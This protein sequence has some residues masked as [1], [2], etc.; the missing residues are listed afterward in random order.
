VD[1][2]RAPS[3]S[4]TSQGLAPGCTRTFGRGKA[5]KKQ[6]EAFDLQLKADRKLGQKPQARSELY[7][8]TLAQAYIRDRKVNGAST[9]YLTDLKNLLNNHVLP[10]LCKKPVDELIYEDMLEI[11]NLYK[12]RS[13]STRNRY[14]VY[15]RA[16]FRFG[17]RH[18][19]NKNNPL[20]QWQKKK[21]PPR[22]SLLTLENLK[23][24]IVHAAP[25]LKWAIEVEWRLGTRPGPSEL[26][27]IKWDHIDFDRGVV[28][29]F[30]GKT[31]EWREIPFSQDFRVRL[32]SMKAQAKTEYVIEYKGRPMK[33]F[34]RSFQTACSKAGVSYSCRMYDVRH[35]FATVML[36]GGADLAAVSK[37]LGHSSTKMTADVYYELMKGEKAKAV[38]LLPS[39]TESDDTAEKIIPFRGNVIQ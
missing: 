30:A 34:R 36:S 37:L 13:Q 12:E 20:A 18:G 16:I 32:L 28:R 3:D 14:F 25:H 21:E 9:S 2:Q 15:L 17:I 8:D 27:S 24:I 35:L 7:F 4:L 11:A 23:K 29:V 1:V 19:L 38:S 10:V 39:I 33:K 26:L 31:R 6:A 22:Q 5:G